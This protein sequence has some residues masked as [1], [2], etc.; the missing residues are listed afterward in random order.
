MPLA[1]CKV[2]EEPGV[3]C[4][5]SSCPGSGRCVIK[6]Q[7]VVD[8][9][10]TVNFGTL[11]LWCV[12]VC[13]FT[14]CGIVDLTDMVLPPWPNQGH[15]LFGLFTTFGYLPQN[16]PTSRLIP[17]PPNN[18]HHHPPPSGTQPVCS[19]G[20]ARPLSPMMCAL[21]SSSAY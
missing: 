16:A 4:K 11:F 10:V 14:P 2:Q 9:H 6:R 19:F 13:L 17:P 15:A 5:A 3:T 1:G 21:P 8:K 12:C 20:L 7:D 18:A